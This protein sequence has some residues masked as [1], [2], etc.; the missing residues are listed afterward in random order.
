[1]DNELYYSLKE[2][3]IGRRVGRRTNRLL[4]KYY[5]CL[6]EPRFSG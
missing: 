3:D 6:C 5:T 1:M 4:K 2:R